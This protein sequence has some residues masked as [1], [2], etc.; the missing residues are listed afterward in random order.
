MIK[1]YTCILC[2][3][4]NYYLYSF[5]PL[6]YMFP[7]CTA[8]P[9]RPFLECSLVISPGGVI[10]FFGFFSS[11]N[12]V[13]NYR[14]VPSPTPS[15]CPSD[16]LVSPSEDYSCSGLVLG[17]NYS[18]NVGAINCGNQEGPGSTIIVQPQGNID[19]LYIIL[20]HCYNIY[21]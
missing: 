9:T 3:V 21:F 10:V 16:Q 13:T 20:F 15:S 5:S 1:M 12:N 2:L 18:F 14:V 11:G 6:H 19:L 7:C 17:T 4:Y 8:P